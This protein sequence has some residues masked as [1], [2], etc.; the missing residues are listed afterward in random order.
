MSSKISQDKTMRN[1]TSEK[2]N[3]KENESERQ[4]EKDNS[5]LFIQEISLSPKD[6]SYN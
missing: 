5:E 4:T 1:T 3:E 6:L 2:G